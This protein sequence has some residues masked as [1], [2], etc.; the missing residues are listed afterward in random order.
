MAAKKKNIEI[1]NEVLNEEVEVAEPVEEPVEEPKAPKKAKASKKEERVK[2]MVPYIEGEEPEITVG[3]N[4]KFTKIRRGV[5]VEV[6][7][8]VAE[9]LKNS[10]RQM[11]AALDQQK[12]FENQEFEW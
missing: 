6:P 12:K 11:M 4:G 3:I 1:E 9:L 2:I 8:Y 5:E 7:W 10:N